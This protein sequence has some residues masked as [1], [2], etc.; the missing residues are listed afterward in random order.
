MPRKTVP[1]ES[2][3]V[4]ENKVLESIFCTT[5]D[6]EKKLHS[7]N[8]K[9]LY[10]PKLRQDLEDEQA[11]ILLTREKLDSLI[12]EAA[13]SIPAHKSVLDYLIP[14]FKRVTKLINGMRENSESKRA[15]LKEAERLC[16]SYCIFAIEVPDLFG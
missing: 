14:C 2:I 9:L 15:I 10:L 6:S 11:P 8:R 1:E 5:L 4:Y 3:E 12:L 16:L 7:S 13:S